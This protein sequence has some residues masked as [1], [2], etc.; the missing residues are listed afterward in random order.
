MSVGIPV[1]KFD[2]DNTSGTLARQ[3]SSWAEGVI[4]FQEEYLAGA[5]QEQLEALGYTADEVA[6]L[7]SAISDLYK[8]AQ[9]YYGEAEQT[10]A[11]DFRTFASRLVGIQI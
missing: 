6:L 8:L 1:G 11:Y 5:T 10:P 2:V 7:K 9:V 4:K 3:I